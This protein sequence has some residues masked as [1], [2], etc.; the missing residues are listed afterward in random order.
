[1]AEKTKEQLIKDY[2]TE[3]ITTLK[4]LSAV[5]K[6]PGM[7]V[8]STQ[9]IDGHNSRALIQIAQEVLSNAVDEAYAGFGKHI[10]MTINK[11]GSMTVCD[12]GR[13]MPRGENY[14]DV[15]RAM[16]VLHSSG[17][18]DANSYASS[19]GQNGLGNKLTN[20]LSVFIKIEAVTTSK[21]HY[22]IKFQQENVVEKK[23]LPYDKS[24]HT[25]TTV[26]FLPDD[27]IFDMVDWEDEPL[28]N[29]LEQ[30]AYL[31]PG[32]KFEFDDLRKPAIDGDEKHDHY[33]REWLSEHGL[34]DYVADIAKD[35]SLVPGVKK[36]IDFKGE[37]QYDQQLKSTNGQISHNKGTIQVSGALIYVEDSGT[38]IYSFANGAPTVDGGYHVDGAK[39][40]ISRAFRDYANDKKILKGKQSFDA[41]DTRDGLILTLLV[42]IPENIL[43]FESQSKTKLSTAAAKSATQKIIYDN[44]TTWLYDHPKAAKSI[45]LNMA[46]SKKYRESAVASKKAAQKARRTGAKKAVISEKLKTASSRNPAQKSLYITE[47]D[48]A[49]LA[50]DTL[51]RLADGRNLSIKDVV[52]EFQA[53]EK[54]YVYS[55]GRADSVKHNKFGLPFMAEPI[56][57]ARV[58]RR[59]AKLIRL[60]LDT[61]EHLDCTPDHQI[62]LAD[63]SFK[64]ADQLTKFDSL[65]IMR[66]NIHKG[67][68]MFDSIGL[69]RFI[70]QQYDPYHRFSNHHTGDPQKDVEVHHIDGNKLNNTPENLRIL[71]RH[72]HALIT[73]DQTNKKLGETFGQ[74]T[75][76]LYHT[77]PDYYQRQKEIQAY[78]GHCSRGIKRSKHTTEQNQITSQTTS[79]AMQKISKDRWHEMRLSQQ[80]TCSLALVK[81]MLENGVKFED[82]K[83]YTTPSETGS[84]RVRK[85]PSGKYM[86]YMAYW[87]LKFRGNSHATGMI[88]PTLRSHFNSDEE[89]LEAV[90][91]SNHKVVKIEELS[92]RQDV[93][94][95]T[96]PNTHNFVLANDMIVHNCAELTMVRD[97]R[98]QAVFPIRGKIENAWRVKAYKALANKEISTIASVLGAGFGKDFDVNKL[99][100]DKV[101]LAEDSDQDG[102]HIASLLIALFYKFFPGLIQGGHLYR[103]IAPLYQA[104]LKHKKTGEMKYVLAYSEQEHDQYEKE[105]EEALKNGYQLVGNEERWKGLGSMNPEQTRRYLADPRYRRLYQ[106][107]IDDNDQARQMIELWM[108]KNADPRKEAV[109]SEADFDTS[110]LD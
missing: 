93:Y 79:A 48:S 27:T 10:S 103:V 43:Q 100:Y 78:G 64:R 85:G 95:L 82:Y 21:E 46:D 17:K 67:Y 22:M 32:V 104:E 4:G 49:C 91:N 89:L 19:I 107:K 71:T 102:D 29:K 2:Q 30:T 53:G 45:I 7:Y 106:I 37:Y 6:R 60:T 96:I 28:V 51:I 15:I 77:D 97:K 86:T 12:E 73:E 13:G 47:G 81:T 3:G 57:D 8:G 9:S 92:E 75:S 69:H 63:G 80:F 65:G 33:H 31:T 74:R 18:F 109:F 14:D 90:R 72:E 76:R 58:T 99:Q 52:K 34:T 66:N 44:L 101:I 26:T 11:D 1:M 41:Q 55:S 105:L 108:G 54:L 36:P 84:L 5:R 25:G 24:M 42:K 68:L 40:A 87:K 23:M 110:E 98:Y 39:M 35:S 83:K 59:N 88:Y 94:D 20:A 70:A 61:G 62:M 56:Q 50:G 38:D 16:T